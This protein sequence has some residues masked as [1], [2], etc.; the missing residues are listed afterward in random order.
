MIMKP[1]IKAIYVAV[2]NM[3]RAVKFYDDIFGV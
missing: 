3:D 1:Q 2:K